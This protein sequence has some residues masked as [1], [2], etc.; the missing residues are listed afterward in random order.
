MRSTYGNGAP[1]LLPFLPSDVVELHALNVLL[2]RSSRS[3]V[4]QQIARAAHPGNRY[5]VSGAVM[6]TYNRLVL[7]TGL[8][9]GIVR[10]D[11]RSLTGVKSVGAPCP[12][13]LHARRER[14]HDL[15]MFW[16]IDRDKL[17]LLY[18]N[19]RSNGHLGMFSRLE[20]KGVF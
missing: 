14:Q 20:K 19:E 16:Y 9:Y 4:L 15:G 8:T 6:M 18:A 11:I 1:A 7:E 5:Y 10:Q 13:V 17:Q 2:R 3:F 12:V